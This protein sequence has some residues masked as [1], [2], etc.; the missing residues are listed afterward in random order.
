MT[1][2]LVNKKLK[3][4]VSKEFDHK[5]TVSFNFPKYQE[6]GTPHSVWERNVNNVEKVLE[7]I[8]S[9]QPLADDFPLVHIRREEKDEE[10]SLIRVHLDVYGKA[11]LV[12]FAVHLLKLAENLYVTI[13]NISAQSGEEHQ[14]YVNVLLDNFQ[15][16]NSGDPESLG[17][18]G[19]QTLNYLEK[20]GVDV[21][22]IKSSI[23]NGSYDVGSTTNMVTDSDIDGPLSFESDEGV[24]NLLVMPN[25]NIDDVN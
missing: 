10:D 25:Y 1:D 8:L 7:E 4:V 17:K 21:K 3:E 24:S 19:I 12:K 6:I 13:N 22:D 11:T 20:I 5:E 23:S 9:S 16:I 15:A 2:D 18:L 14:D